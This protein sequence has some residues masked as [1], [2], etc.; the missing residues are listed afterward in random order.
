MS[1]HAVLKSH[2]C[3]IEPAIPVQVVVEDAHVSHVWNPRSNVTGGLHVQDVFQK[4]PNVFT[5]L[6]REKGRMPLGLPL[7]VP[8]HSC[9]ILNT[10]TLFPYPIPLR[11]IYLLL[12][13][14]GSVRRHPHILI[15]PPSLLVRLLPRLQHRHSSR[16]TPSR[17]MGWVILKILKV[18]KAIS[19][20]HT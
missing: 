11:P 1:T 7:I 13:S 18:L 16:C 19:K 12:T 3:V 8:L 4:G 20:R 14:I 17:P 10:I 9:I 5:D 6:Q 2:V 15:I